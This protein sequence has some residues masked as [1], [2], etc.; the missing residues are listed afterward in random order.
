MVR[1]TQKTKKR[2][3][4][5]A[6]NWFYNQLRDYRGLKQIDKTWDFEFRGTPVEVKSAQ[7]CIRRSP[8]K[9]VRYN[10]TGFTL[11][12]KQHKELLKNNAWYCFVLMRN[13]KC[14]DA[15]MI[16]SNKVYPHMMLRKNSHRVHIR[17][18][19]GVFYSRNATPI[20]KFAEMHVS[21]DLK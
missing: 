20:K 14:L 9:E 16:P 8:L 21:G 6:E 4:E 10:W 3:G 18:R 19:F 2:L 17:I 15:V 13:K 1:W 7:L 5:I 11:E 12:D